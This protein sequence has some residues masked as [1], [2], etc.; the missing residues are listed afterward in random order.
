MVNNNHTYEMLCIDQN[1][2][3]VFHNLIK[4]NLSPVL[5]KVNDY[6]VLTSKNT[7]QYMKDDSEPFSIKMR[8]DMNKCIIGPIYFLENEYTNDIYKKMRNKRRDYVDNENIEE[9]YWDD[10]IFENIYDAMRYRYFNR[11][12]YILCGF[13]MEK[14]VLIMNYVSITQCLKCGKRYSSEFD[15]FFEEF[16]EYKISPCKEK[17]FT[18]NIDESNKYEIF[19]SSK[20]TVKLWNIGT[21][22]FENEFQTMKGVKTNVLPDFLH[23]C[24]VYSHFDI[25]TMD[26]KIKLIKSLLIEDTKRKKFGDNLEI[27]TLTSE[28]CNLKLDFYSGD[29]TV[30]FFEGCVTIKK[31]VGTFVIKETDDSHLIFTFRYGNSIKTYDMD[32]KTIIRKI[33]GGS[34]ILKYEIEFDKFITVE[35][36]DCNGNNECVYCSDS[37]RFFYF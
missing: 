15:T 36:G 31:I 11:E 30:T 33:E 20:E 27:V 25:I 1:I 12:F 13:K 14:N 2:T 17:Y 22:D 5:T 21:V 28:C 18:V 10:I 32:V 4:N 3:D 23:F 34:M 24:G 7:I 37:N 29:M 19:P 9:K 26:T 35:H 16:D 8:F 6:I